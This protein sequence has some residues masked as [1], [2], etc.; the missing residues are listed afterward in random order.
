MEGANRCD[1]CFF[2]LNWPVGS[3]CLFLCRAESALLDTKAP[4]KQN[5]CCGKVV[6]LWA[7]VLVPGAVSLHENLVDTILCPSAH[8]L[9]PVNIQETLHQPFPRPQS[10]WLAPKQETFI[11]RDAAWASGKP[12]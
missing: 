9:S 2:F 4:A 10:W 5:H 1:L 11:G 8:F 12:K 7:S 3:Q 6:G